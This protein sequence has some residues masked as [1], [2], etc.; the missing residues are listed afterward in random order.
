MALVISESEVRLLRRV[1]ELVCP[2]REKRPRASAVSDNKEGVLKYINSK[3]RSKENI[4]L[5]LVEDDHFIPIIQWGRR[6]SRG[7]QCVLCLS[8]W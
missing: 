3:R 4:G 1:S 2:C 8:F 6:K 5:I 7:V